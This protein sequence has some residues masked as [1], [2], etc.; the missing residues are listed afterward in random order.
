[1]AFNLLGF[2]CALL[3]TLIFV[4]QNIWSKRMFNDRRLDKLNMLLYSS[5]MSFLLMT[6]LW[7]W[8]EGH[9]MLFDGDLSTATTAP[10][11][12]PDTPLSS[13]SSDTHWFLVQWLLP[14]SD[15]PTL[16]IMTL[17]F[18]NGCS[19]FCQNV[20]AFSILSLVSPV[21]YSIA[22][23]IKR[24]VVIVVSLV[25][26]G[27]AVSGMQAVGI[28][29]TFGGLWMYQR[30]KL[31]GGER[32]P[33]SASAQGSGGKRLISSPTET[34][35]FSPNV[36]SAVT[37]AT[38]GL[39]QHRKQFTPTAFSASRIDAYGN[40]DDGNI[41]NEDDVVRQFAEKSQRVYYASSDSIAIA[42][43][44]SAISVNK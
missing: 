17:F 29:L 19:H 27:Q 8:S 1:L 35:D 22:S 40:N 26:F 33:A 16:T 25:W 38:A 42:M 34:V 15:F 20:F 6:P 14:H 10:N 24:I 43:H 7:F 31:R 2:L 37:S 36:T 11:T 3:S 5:T 39:M 9:A 28:I 21:T 18:L 4:V 41:I 44:P 12:S 32:V 13:N 23:L 30:A